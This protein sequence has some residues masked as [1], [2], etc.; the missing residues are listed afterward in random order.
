LFLSGSI[1][2][3]G[4]IDAFCQEVGNRLSDEE[5]V[6]LASLAGEE[7]MEVSYAFGRSL[8][9]QGKYQGERIRFYFRRKDE[10]P[11][12]LAERIGTVFYT[13][14][15]VEPL[16]EQVLEDCRATLVIGGGARTAEEVDAAR[17]LGVPI[18]PLASSGGTA[19]AT[20]DSMVAEAHLLEY[21][22]A[23]VDKREFGLLADENVQIACGAAVRL[24]RK[25]MYLP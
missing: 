19:K 16:R 17:R 10:K 2:S 21:G 5:R 15:D 8:R 24:V 6:E 13:S 12:P 14:E 20:W 4:N 3:G 9:A 23:L 18:V 22:G 7:A 1:P 25:A 11:P